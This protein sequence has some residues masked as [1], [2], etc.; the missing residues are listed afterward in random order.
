MNERGNGI[1]Q[2]DLCITDTYLGDSERKGSLEYIGL[3]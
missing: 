1:N 2:T 3:P